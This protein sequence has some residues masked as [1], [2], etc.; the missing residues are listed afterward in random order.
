MALC[1]CL[2]EHQGSQERGVRNLGM[3]RSHSA[4]TPGGFC[5]SERQKIKETLLRHLLSFKIWTT[6]CPHTSPCSC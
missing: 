2:L 6:H 4:L 5:D 3:D 1:Q